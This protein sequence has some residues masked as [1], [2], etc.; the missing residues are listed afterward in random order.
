MSRPNGPSDAWTIGSTPT[1]SWGNNLGALENVRLESRDGGAT[2]P[3]VMLAST[4]SDGKQKM[5]V[6]PAW[7]APNA[8]VRVV[9]VA[10][11]SRFDTSNA[12]FPIQ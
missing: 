1:I 2:Y 3:T 12:A 6:S 4:P 8:R 10:D 9:W 11:P 5:T 7:A